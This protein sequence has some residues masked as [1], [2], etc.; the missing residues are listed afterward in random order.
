MCVH[1]CSHPPHPHPALVCDHFQTHSAVERFDPPGRGPS[2]PS[3]LFPLQAIFNLPPFVCSSPPNPP[4]AALPL[5]LCPSL[6]SHSLLRSLLRSFQWCFPLLSWQ[7]RAIPDSPQGMTGFS[8]LSLL[9]LVSPSPLSAEKPAAGKCHD[10]RNHNIKSIPHSVLQR[11]Y[12]AHVGSIQPPWLSDF[13]S[14][15]LTVGGFYQ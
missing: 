12:R 10:N 3:S 6:R 9:E 14:D 8:R 11:S 2:S 4:H 7:V 5:S 15:L 1:V 13:T